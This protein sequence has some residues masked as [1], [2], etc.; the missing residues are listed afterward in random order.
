MKKPR[1]PS[2]HMLRSAELLAEL[3]GGFV[4]CLHLKLTV[5]SLSLYLEAL[6][7]L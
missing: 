2:R 4:R 7:V 1:Q 6:M 5:N 3:A